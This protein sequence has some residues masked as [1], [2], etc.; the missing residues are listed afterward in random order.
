VAVIPLGFLRA[1]P[2][3]RAIPTHHGI[4]ANLVWSAP[5]LIMTVLLGAM[6]VSLWRSRPT[7]SST[8][9]EGTAAPE[10][11]GEPALET[12]ISTA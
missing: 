6:W 5:S 4:I 12:E 7:A 1:Y 2:L 9:D 3:T 8:S 10:A 11:A